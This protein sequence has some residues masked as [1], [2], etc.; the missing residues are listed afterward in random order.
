MTKEELL[1]MG[2]AEE[3]AEKLRQSISRLEKENADLK[4]AVS[5]KEQCLKDLEAARS[6]AE[7]LNARL[8]QAKEE[9]AKA[10]EAYN[11]EITQLK[12]TGGIEKALI[13][14]G[15]KNLKAA[16]SLLDREKI[17][18]NENGD[19]LGLEQQLEAIKQSDPY[20]FKDI[21]EERPAIRGLTA[22]TPEEGADENSE[23][24]DFSQMTY[25]QITDYLA[26]TETS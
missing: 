19:L 17:T 10:G 3:A 25:S 16:G 13:T 23:E 11:R 5:D 14:A 9:A 21:G 12:L 22:Y 6:E 20:L 26:R 8:K 1:S 7:S 15:A 2:I 18:L 4:E 24:A